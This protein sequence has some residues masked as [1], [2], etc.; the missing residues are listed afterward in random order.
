MVFSHPLWG[1]KLPHREGIY[2]GFALGLS[3][4]RRSLLEERIYVHLHFLDVSA[5]SS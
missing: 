4:G 2:D 3:P 5:F 1:H